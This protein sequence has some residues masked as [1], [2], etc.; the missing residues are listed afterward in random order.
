MAREGFQTSDSV[1]ERPLSQS[2]LP[3]G[4]FLPTILTRLCESYVAAL[5]EGGTGFDG[6]ETTTATLV[7]AAYHAALNV[8]YR[9]KSLR[10]GRSELPTEGLPLRIRKSNVMIRWLISCCDYTYAISSTPGFRQ[11]VFVDTPRQPGRW[12]RRRPR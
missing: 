3:P 9:V 12:H 10:D 2:M 1:P 7:R 4:E 6:L 5:F 8:N 11:I